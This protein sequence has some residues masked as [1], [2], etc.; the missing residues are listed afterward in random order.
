[1]ALGG[2]LLAGSPLS[3]VRMPGR[4]TRGVMFVAV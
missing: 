2:L 1:M 3:G 4:R